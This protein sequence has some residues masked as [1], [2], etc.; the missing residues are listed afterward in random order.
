MSN[1]RVSID[2]TLGGQFVI[3]LLGNS[4]TDPKTFNVLADIV[5]GIATGEYQGKIRMNLNAAQAVGSVTFS[6]IADADTITVNGVVITAKTSPAGAQQFAVGASDEAASNNFLALINASALNKIVGCVAAQRK[7][8]IVLSGIVDGDQVTINSVV[9]TAKNSPDPSDNRQFMVGG[10]DSISALNLQTAI[11][12]VTAKFPASLS[13]ITVTVS[14]AT[15]TLLYK[16]SLTI[17]NS[18]HAIISSNITNIVCLIPGQIGN[19]CTLAISAHGSVVAPTG[20]TEGTER[21][22]DDN[23]KQ[24]L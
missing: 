11:S 8:T 22:D 24:A 17:S 23:N 20:G 14:A 9:F 19:L 3:D 18:A 13:G 2:T 1:H 4:P 6:S 7:S 15:L 10:T 5:R 21:I 12:N 16:G